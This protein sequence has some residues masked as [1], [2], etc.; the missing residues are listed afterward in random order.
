MSEIE[1]PYG[2]YWSTPFARWQ[3]SLSHLHSLKFAAHVAKD[4]LTRRK[5]APENFDYAAL[6]MSVP[7]KGSFYGLPWLAG[8]MGVPHLAGP[9][10]SQA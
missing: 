10:I 7:Q 4:A 2:A 8:E 1:I 9:T 5:I 3:G 6:G